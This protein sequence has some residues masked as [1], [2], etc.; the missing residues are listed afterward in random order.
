MRAA[1]AEVPPP[2]AEALHFPVEPGPFRMAMGLTACAEADWLEIDDRYPEEMAERRDLLATR[3]AEVLAM[4][5]GAEA[6]G[7]EL[8]GM[9]A[10][11]LVRHHPAWFRRDGA[12]LENG[13]TGE[14]W[15]I[16]PPELDPLEL[17]GRLVQEDFCII[18]P[19]PEGPVLEAAV[20][21]AP[22]RWRL[23]EKI[24][25]PLQ[26]VHGPVPLYGARLG[27]PVDRFMG[28]LKPG[29]IAL[30]MNCSVVDDPALF[31]PWGKFRTQADPGFTPENVGGRL[32]FRTERQ[33]FRRLDASGTVAFGIRVHSYPLAR[34][35][36]DPARAQVLAAAVRDL[37][38]EMRAYKSIP[39]FEGPL[40][41]FLD[42]ASHAAR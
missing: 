6:A 20:L 23:G 40:L 38:A 2:P 27:A 16:D 11:H 7:A 3:R 32:F 28:A 29:R 41:A 15:W 19:A 25:H 33:T 31:Q 18:R 1:T 39:V 5:P 36:A 24:G 17:A 34:I 42:R 10:A 12:A 9:L 8:L 22:S 30:R 14:R 21:C 13:L 4:Q 26:A 35:S 37:P